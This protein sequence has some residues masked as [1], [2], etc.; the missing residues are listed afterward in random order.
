MVKY[1]VLNWGVT[2]A[3]SL[4]FLLLSFLPVELYGQIRIIVANISTFGS[5]LSLGFPIF[6]VANR[7]YLRRQQFAD[8]LASF[9]VFQLFLLLLI[10]L[11]FF[12][13]VL[14]TGQSARYSLLLPVCV[15]S[16]CFFYSI[17]SL[18]SG[19]YQSFS[20]HGHYLYVF[21]V[22]KLTLFLVITIGYLL[23]RSEYSLLFFPLS[24]LVSFLLLHRYFQRFFLYLSACEWAS[25]YSPGFLIHKLAP[26][27]CQTGPP[28]VLTLIS[29]LSAN[30][31]F[32]YALFS[33]TS[34]QTVG[35][36][37]RGSLL[38]LFITSLFAPLVSKHVTNIGRSSPSFS[39]ILTIQARIFLACLVLVLFLGLALSLAPNCLGLVLTPS[40]VF[41]SRLALLKALCWASVCLTGS[42][43]YHLHLRKAILLT[44]VM[45]FLLLLFVCFVHPSITSLVLAQSLGY[46]LA[47]CIF[48]C[49]LKLTNGKTY[50]SASQSNQSV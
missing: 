49:I 9:L 38:Y 29:I 41:Y 25:F 21:S 22:E 12:S 50:N 30:F 15:F 4:C 32:V 11:S 24:Y 40:L 1:Y 34:L 2:L 3:S 48:V 37:S 36:Y 18:V 33:G 31:E 20:L 7:K 44:S 45:Q 16:C 43:L 35:E 8:Y 27:I 46:I 5:L 42:I 6:L 23:F 39:S 28:F 14:V 19:F 47:A 17:F 26:F 10:A 13:F